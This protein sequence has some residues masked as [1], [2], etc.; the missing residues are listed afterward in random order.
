MEDIHVES[1]MLSGDENIVDIKFT[2]FLLIMDAGKFLFNI[3]APEATVKAAAEGAM[4]EIVGKTP[5]QPILA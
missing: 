1:L 5:I 3:R 2:V 4:R